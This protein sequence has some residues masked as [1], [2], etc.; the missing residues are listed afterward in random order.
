VQV[1]Q[2]KVTQM[3][4]G[5]RSLVAVIVVGDSADDLNGGIA[6]DCSDWGSARAARFTRN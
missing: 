1:H 2:Q 6:D 4:D 3:V 5:K